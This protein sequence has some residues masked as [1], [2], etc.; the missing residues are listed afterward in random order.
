MI[1]VLGIIRQEGHYSIRIGDSRRVLSISQLVLFTNF[2]SSC[3]SRSRVGVLDLRSVTTEQA[4]HLCP[5]TTRAIRNYWGA[6]TSVP[7]ADHGVSV[8]PFLYTIDEF[9]D[10]NVIRSDRQVEQR[11]E[12]LFLLLPSC[13]VITT[14]A[15]GPTIAETAQE[16]HRTN[17][18][19]WISTR[20]SVRTSERFRNE[21]YG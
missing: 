5:D 3:K 15:Y 6:F 13:L 14:N 18:K 11:T 19:T 2:S 9:G 4:A 16:D 7:C 8:R 1:L 21:E 20:T 12:Q 17:G 10:K